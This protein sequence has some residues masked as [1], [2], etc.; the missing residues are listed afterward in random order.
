MEAW[1]QR[2]GDRSEWL[3]CCPCKSESSSCS[4]RIPDI[5]QNHSHIKLLLEQLPTS[6]SRTEGA[7]HAGRRAEGSCRWDRTGR[8]VLRREVLRGGDGEL[9]RSALG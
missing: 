7:T 9:P 4:S 5:P 2:P 1:H 3:R 8:R 6:S